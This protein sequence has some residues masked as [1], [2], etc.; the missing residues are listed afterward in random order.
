MFYFFMTLVKVNVK[1]TKFEQFGQKIYPYG[2]DNYLS[3]KKWL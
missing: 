2:L 1:G 3:K